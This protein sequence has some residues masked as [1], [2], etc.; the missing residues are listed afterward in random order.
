M[1]LDKYKLEYYINLYKE[2]IIKYLPIEKKYELLKEKEYTYEQIKEKLGSN[3]DE[4]KRVPKILFHGSKQ[5]LD[6]IYAKESS[7]KGAHVYATDN[8][9]QAFFFSVFRK[10]SQARAKILENIDEE[11]PRYQYFI[12]LL[13]LATL[14]GVTG[15]SHPQVKRIAYYFSIP[16]DLVIYGYIPKKVP[17][18]SRSLTFVILCIYVLARFTLTAYILKQGHLIPY[19]F[20]WN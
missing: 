18:Q 4:L 15:F 2:D 20:R 8:P 5:T 17:E 1:E 14:I 10:S 11:E 19:E 16:A 12:T 7:Q 9:I 3:A 13:I 6:I